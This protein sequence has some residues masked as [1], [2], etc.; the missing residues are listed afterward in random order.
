LLN[1]HTVDAD[2]K[3]TISR[4]ELELRH[5]VQLLKTDFVSSAAAIRR[6]AD[7]RVAAAESRATDSQNAADR[8]V[9]AAR[10]R[11]DSRVLALEEQL[12]AAKV[13]YGELQRQHR[14]V[15]EVT[16]AGT[17]DFGPFYWKSSTHPE[18]LA[19]YSRYKH[20]TKQSFYRITATSAAVTAGWAY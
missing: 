13:Q 5:T 19:E 2:R 20:P 16:P 15:T 9:S 11:C 8:R 12:H 17:F 14:R 10:H 6:E 18:V 4:F 3:E 1:L 7:S